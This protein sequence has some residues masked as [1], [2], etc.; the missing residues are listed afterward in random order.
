MLFNL[1]RNTALIS[2]KILNSRLSNK[3]EGYVLKEHPS[4]CDATPIFIV[5]APRTGS[6]LLYQL[7]VEHFKL[8]YLSNFASLF[9]SVPYLSSVVAQKS[10]SNKDTV[11]LYKSEFGFVKGLM[12]P[13]EAS[14]VI[15]HWFGDDDYQVNTDHMLHNYTCKKINALVK[16]F[17]GPILI[18]NMKLCLKMSQLS[19]IFPNAVFIHIKRDPLYTAQS[20]LQARQKIYGTMDKWW[21]F[22]VPGYEELEKKSCYVQ[23][24]QQVNIVNRQIENQYQQ[25][26]RKKVITIRYEE[27]CEH[28]Q[29][30]LNQLMLELPFLSKK[31]NNNSTA[32]NRLVLIKNANQKKL[33]E[34][35]WQKLLDAYQQ[36]ES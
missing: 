30:V 8:A 19:K 23:V 3:L 22:K 36:I 2:Q 10:I 16:L 33:D 24:I 29:T 6:T 26:E 1:F 35:H 28:P 27:L 31:P 32:L 21:S 14:K 18:K 9:Y 20:I 11:S 25:I 17:G 5:G 34:P 4:T 13:S 15:E 12:A 7:M